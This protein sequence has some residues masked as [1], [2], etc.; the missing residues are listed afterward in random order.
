M[1]P[2]PDLSHEIEA[3]QRQ[4]GL[5]PHLPPHVTVKAP[6]GL[7]DAPTWRP[8]ARTALAVVAPRELTLG[9]VAWF[10][11][12]VAY[13]SVLGELMDLHQAALD[14]TVGGRGDEHEGDAYTPHLTIGT[15]FTKAAPERRAEIETAGAVFVG[16]TFR[17][18]EVVEFHRESQTAGYGIAQRFPLSA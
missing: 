6:P 15:R 18:T 2:P 7:V 16:C 17:V 5:R 3:L 9:A 10:G 12:R 14:A 1:V 13:L 11:T 4:L 8:R